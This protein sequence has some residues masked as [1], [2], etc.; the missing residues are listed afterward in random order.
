[1]R[2]LHH[3]CIQ[4]DKYEESVKFY[5][6]ILGFDLVKESKNF[7]RRLFNSWLQQG[8]LMI[9]L[10]TNKGNEPLIDF[11]KNS[12]GMV[13]FCIIVDN[14]EEEYMRIKNLGFN[15]FNSKGGKDIYKVEN[16]KLFKIVAPEGTIIEIRD[17]AEI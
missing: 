17:Q 12:K 5:T 9:E 14:I 10:Q 2:R 11:N 13:H 3:I 6:D 8:E 4:S 15:I 16:G 7:H 1:M